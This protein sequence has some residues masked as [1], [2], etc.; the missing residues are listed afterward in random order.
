MR[1]VAEILITV[2]AGF[3]AITTWG[4][5]GALGVLIWLYIRL[6]AAPRDSGR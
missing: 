4:P 5:A 6:I 1:A 2:V 3:I